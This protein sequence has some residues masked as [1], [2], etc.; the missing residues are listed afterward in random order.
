MLLSVLVFVMAGAINP[1]TYVV[2]YLMK[3][4][5]LCFFNR[6]M[7]AYAKLRRGCVLIS[8]RRAI[9]KRNAA[10]EIDHLVDVTTFSSH[11]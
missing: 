4:C 7:G 10:K 6:C 5:L 1:V 11:N 9:H 3:D 2:D 8:G